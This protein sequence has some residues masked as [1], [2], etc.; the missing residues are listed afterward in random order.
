M[1]THIKTLEKRIEAMKAKATELWETNPEGAN[2][3]ESV[4]IA[5]EEEALESA[6]KSLAEYNATH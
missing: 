6:R 3:Y 4:I 2:Y 5:P 1:K